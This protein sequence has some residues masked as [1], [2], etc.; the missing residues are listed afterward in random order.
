MKKAIR[1]FPWRNP[2]FQK[3]QVYT[4]AAVWD[5]RWGYRLLKPKNEQIPAKKHSTPVHYKRHYTPF[6][7]YG[8]APGFPPVPKGAYTILSLR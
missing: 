8:E 6:Q 4:P 1:R 5:T 3:A 7:K 2:D